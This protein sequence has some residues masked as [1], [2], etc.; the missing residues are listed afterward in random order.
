ML[1]DETKCNVK[2][3][4]IDTLR[5][6]GSE[7]CSGTSAVHE[8]LLQPNEFEIAPALEKPT[9]KMGAM[10]DELYKIYKIREVNHDDI[11][12]ASDKI[13]Y[14]KGK[15][16][17]NKIDNV[18]NKCY[19]Y[20]KNR[21]LFEENNDLN[22]EYVF[23]DNKSRIKLFDCIN[24]VKNNEDI[25]KLLYPDYLLEKPISE[26]EKALFINVK[27]IYKDKEITLKL[28]SKLDNYVINTETNEII[29]NDLKTTGHFLT[30]FDNSFVKYHYNR[31]MAYYLWLLYIYTKHKFNF[32]PSKINANMLVV[33]TIPQYNSCVYKV[34]N[35]QINKGF[36][37]FTNLL[38]RVAYLKLKESG[39]LET[40][41]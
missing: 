40:D 16:D 38:K 32:E 21:K 6:F 8:L 3:Y 5:V 31:Q 25:Q 17:D 28:K 14:Y 34:S 7:N 23:L 2:E 33:S 13:D 1:H 15:M 36:K 18:Y 37:E 27:A 26:N 24:S 19:K 22:K 39:F 10:A 9:A 35:N 12:E 41:L 29:L 30:E 11:I 20:W 4:R